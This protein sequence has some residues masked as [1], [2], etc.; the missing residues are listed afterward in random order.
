MLPPGFWPFCL[1]LAL[2]H[3]FSLLPCSYHLLCV[4]VSQISLSLSPIRTPVSGFGAQMESRMISSWDRHL[5]CICRDF[6]FFFK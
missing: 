4:S 2:A 1:S 5:N 6:F 3:P